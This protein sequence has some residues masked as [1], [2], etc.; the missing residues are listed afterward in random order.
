MKFREKIVSIKTVIFDL[1]GVLTDGLIGYGKEDE[2]KFF[3]VRDGYGINMARRLGLKVGILSGRAAEANRRR[4]KE[5]EL[6]FFY[7]GKKDKKKA[8]DELLAEQS[9]NP[10]ECAYLGDDMIDIPILTRCG[11]SAVTADAP[12][13]M[14]E[15]CDFR[16]H[17]S[18]GRGAAR[19]VIDM[20][21]HEKGLLDK[22]LQKYKE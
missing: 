14:D 18:G 22:F 21:L 17:S 8:F 15:F 13:Y 16:T 6:D 4:S 7:E 11:F 10:S 1:D 9:L 3:H 5:L 2:I 19:E 20:I 12:K